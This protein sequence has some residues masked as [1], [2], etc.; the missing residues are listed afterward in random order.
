MGWYLHK[1]AIYV[2]VCTSNM[3][4]IF[5]TIAT[6]LTNNNEIKALQERFRVV[7]QPTKVIGLKRSWLALFLAHIQ[8]KIPPLIVVQNEAVARE[9]V[10][11]LQLF[12][13]AAIAIDGLNSRLYDPT[14]GLGERTAQLQKISHSGAIVVVPIRTLLLKTPSPFDLQK[15][16]F[17]L[18]V[19]TKMSPPQLCA[20]LAEQGY[21]RTSRVS[22]HGEFAVRGEVIDLFSFSDEHPIRIQFNFDTIE[23]IKEFSLD[24][25]RSLCELKALTIAPINSIALDEHHKAHLA[26]HGIDQEHAQANL[27]LFFGL[28]YDQSYSLLDF[29]NP[30]RPLILADFDHLESHAEAFEKEAT[31]LYKQAVR[32]GDQVPQPK[33][34]LFSFQDLLDLRSKRLELV[35]FSSHSDHPTDTLA[36]KYEEARSFFGNINFLKEELTTLQKARYTIVIFS[37]NSD[38]ALR[39]KTLLGPDFPIEIIPSGLSSGFS[40]PDAKFIAITEH[41]IFGRKKRTILASAKK[42]ETA[43]IDSFIELTPGDYVVH[44][45]YGVGRFKGIDRLKAAGSERDY[46]ALEYHDND[47]VFVPIEQVNLVQRYIGS[48][49]D[50]P[51]L[52]TLGGK[53]WSAKKARA[54]KSAEELSGYLIDIYAKRQNAQ[55]FAFTHDDPYIKELEMEFDAHFS[56]QETEDQLT[57]MADIKRDMES[58][59]PMDRLVCGDVGY[60]KTELAMR[61]AFKAAISGKQC[62]VLCPT[63][64]LAEQHY[65]N[66]KRRFAPFDFVRITMLSRLVPKKEQTQYLEEINK[67]VI[68]L[69]IGT[70]RVLSKDV[71]FKNLGLLIIDEE[72]RFGVKDKE[73]IKALKNGIDALT[74]TATPIPRTLHMSLVKIRDLSMI[75]TPPANRKP[76]ETFV[77]E[78]NPEA[79]SMAVRRELERG[80]QVFYLHNRVE[81][82]PTICHYLQTLVPEASVE[83]AHGQM[84]ADA[85]DEVMHRFIHKGFNILVSTTIIESGID[86][87]NVNTII[88]DRADMYGVSQLYQLRG[89]VG[90]SDRL[91]YAYLFYPDKTA[92]SEL[93]I[94]RLQIISD[95][96]E[97][98]SGFKI[99]LKDMEVRGAG[100][101][102]GPEQSGEIHA[103][104]FDLYLKL[105]DEAIREK[106]KTPDSEEIVEPYLE[107]D[108]SGFI[109]DSYIEEPSHKM[110]FYKKM[111][112]VE[113]ETEV[114]GIYSELSDRFGPLPEEV[115]SLLSLAEM[116]VL[117][118]KLRI[119]SIK[120]RNGWAEIEFAKLS[121]L[122][123]DHLMSMIKESH[124][125][126]RPSATNPAAL[127]LETGKVGL[128]EKSEF[129]RDRLIRL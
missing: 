120:E 105:L 36:I 122:N 115:S 7:K 84:G 39:L 78:F 9:L 54:R 60:G 118:R 101:L 28:I 64:I 111:A 74:L 44:V 20:K 63:T 114:Q 123:I 99:A 66:F 96:T 48:S 126:I 33:H 55:G 34:V 12:G 103:V 75:K 83:F 43:S 88:I 42:V 57:V 107:L 76:V 112:S 71:Q 53:S 100:N 16:C 89:R 77:Q 95:F 25:Q 72:Q 27:G 22:M 124:G 117:C 59:R 30:E 61:A 37:E 80:G 121:A 35:N 19:S 110:E 119:K 68:D 85:M 47:M 82:L 94:K 62:A 56:F 26:A 108:Y 46:I 18:R 73:R 50:K 23:T 106:N 21:T 109:P 32:K 102:L 11:D 41:E 29:M 52:D 49:G 97:L 87:P 5:S 45:N 86:I 38:Q 4:S 67:G 58:T 69:V 15:N 65:E 51:K 125:K 3:D 116:R 127:L 129:I 98:G 104:G 31:E 17:N 70:H 8:L 13:Q 128:R 93:A 113:T 90:R 6:R 91:A 40:L 2:I 79:I 10:S 81:S 92:L 24:D 14:H 1:R